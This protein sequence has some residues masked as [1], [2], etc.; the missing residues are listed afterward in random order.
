MSTEERKL[1]A[2]V[3]TDICGFTELMGRDESR[4]M[5]LLE[6][7]RTLLKPIVSDF[8]GEWLKEIG[9]GVLLSF[10]STV[11]AVTCSLEVQ[12]VLAD[13]TNPELIDTKNRLK[14]LNRAL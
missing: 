1:A 14:S 6:T 13:K 9:D 3:F 8:D 7:Q 5:A 12:R 2:I 10:P 11:K 4:A